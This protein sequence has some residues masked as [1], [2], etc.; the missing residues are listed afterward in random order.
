MRRC[1][2]PQ[3]YRKRKV[4]SPG[5]WYVSA[6]ALGGEVVGGLGRQRAV[7]AADAGY[8]GEEV[9]ALDGS[10][11]QPHLREEAQEDER[12]RW[13]RRREQGSP[14]TARRSPWPPASWTVP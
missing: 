11:D 10:I 13:W 1:V 7:I 8:T 14:A 4:C 2:L 6:A 5:Q 12:A 3:W 9:V